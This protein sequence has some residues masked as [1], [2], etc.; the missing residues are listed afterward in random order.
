MALESFQS[1][2]DLRGQH[3]EER[4]TYGD[5]HCV[6]HYSFSQEF[7]ASKVEEGKKLRIRAKLLA[8]HNAKETKIEV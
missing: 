6:V 8:I 5:E 2:Q 4:K 3:L 7:A 1:N